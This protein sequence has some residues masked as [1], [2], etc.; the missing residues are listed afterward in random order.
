MTSGLLPT[1][2]ERSLE[3][4]N[5]QLRKEVTA[6]RDALHHLTCALARQD[7][8]YAVRIERGTDIEAQVRIDTVFS[9]RE[10]RTSL[11]PATRSTPLERATARIKGLDSDVST[12]PVPIP[13]CEVER[14][15]P[16]RR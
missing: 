9:P 2:K 1:E 15:D 10:A 4:E 12:G 16:T 7:D 6:L 8:A 5:A 13:T 11:P 14:L 3:R